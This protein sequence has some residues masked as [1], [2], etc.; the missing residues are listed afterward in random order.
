MN[1]QFVPPDMVVMEDE[2]CCQTLSQF[3]GV[4][5]QTRILMA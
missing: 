5:L 2:S 3:T 1:L 4:H